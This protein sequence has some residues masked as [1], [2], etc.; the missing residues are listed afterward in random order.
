MNSWIADW[1]TY[2]ISRFE[3]AEDGPW[4]E[5]ARQRLLMDSLFVQAG[6]AGSIGRIG[7]LQGLVFASRFKQMY[8]AGPPSWVQDTLAFLV[9]PTARLFDIHAYDRPA[10]AGPSR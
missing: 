7:P 3:A 5:L 6:R 8:L 9:A 4:D 10:G 1:P 2:M